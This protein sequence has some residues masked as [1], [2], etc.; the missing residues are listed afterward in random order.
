[1]GVDYN[2]VN[3]A[4]NRTDGNK[5]TRFAD[6]Y[7]RFMGVDEFMGNPNKY[8]AVESF[9]NKSTGTSTHELRRRFPVDEDTAEIIKREYFKKF[10]EEAFG[11]DGVFARKV[12]K[13]SIIEK[14]K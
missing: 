4:R 13:L 10:P 12:K 3:S 2:V 8:Y 7:A 6:V 14:Q 11:S 9:W 1:M 5:S